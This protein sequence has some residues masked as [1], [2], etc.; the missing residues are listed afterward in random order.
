LADI[1]FVWQKELK[2]LGDAVY[3]A[4]HHVNNEPF[5]VLL[6]DTMMDAS[7][8]P[9]KQLLEVFERYQEPVVL[10]EELDRSQVSR[11]GV[12]DGR[13]VDAGLYLVKD[14][15]EKPSADEAPSNLVIAGRYVLTPDIFEYL[16]RTTPS[17]GGEIQLTDAMRM[18]V[19]DRAMYGLQLNGRRCDIGNKEGFVRTNIEFAL[20]RDDIAENLR[21]FIKQLAKEI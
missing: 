1:H 12:I 9:A 7:T 20:K 3:C 21:R 2:G 19:K 10:L 17:K 5:V 6:G 18:M 15:I 11:Y 14:F 16:N 13:E 4:R 8:P